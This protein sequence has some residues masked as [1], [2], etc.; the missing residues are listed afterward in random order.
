MSETLAEVS[1]RVKALVEV[2]VS[3]WWRRVDEFNADEVMWVSETLEERCGGF[4]TYVDVW[5]RTKH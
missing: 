4:N 3:V 2:L 5:I 1:G